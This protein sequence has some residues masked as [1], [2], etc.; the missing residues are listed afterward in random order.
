M[1]NFLRVFSAGFH[2]MW[3][4][5]IISAVA[6]VIVFITAPSFLGFVWISATTVAV[7]QFVALLGG[8]VYGY[9][10]WKLKLDQPKH[11]DVI[12]KSEEGS[13]ETAG[14]K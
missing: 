13:A 1:E 8:A 5:F 14:A 12:L 9:L 6:S 7:V 4:T 11:P 3:M 10:T 2:G